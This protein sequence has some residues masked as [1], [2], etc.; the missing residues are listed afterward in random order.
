MRDSHLSTEHLL[1]PPISSGNRLSKSSTFHSAS[2]QRKSVAPSA[3]LR[4][5]QDDPEYTELLNELKEWRMSFSL[6]AEIKPGVAYVPPTTEQQSAQQHA[7]STGRQSKLSLVRVC[8]SQSQLATMP[9]CDQSLVRNATS[10]PAG[11]ASEAVTPSV[12]SV[13]SDGFT[14]ARPALYSLWPSGH[15]SVRTPDSL[16]DN[17]EATIE[18]YSDLGRRTPQRSNRPRLGLFWKRK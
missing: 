15:G 7:D 3:Q 11:L 13:L 1:S 12:Y 8:D 16:R 6:P 17:I 10:V 4:V 5:M 14:P 9:S 2:T 18:M